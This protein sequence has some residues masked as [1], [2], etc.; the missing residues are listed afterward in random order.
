M[1]GT[2]RYVLALLVT[3]SCWLIHDI[4]RF[5]QRPAMG[6][7]LSSETGWGRYDCVARFHYNS[8]SGA[9]WY[10]FEHESYR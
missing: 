1:L 9:N 2:F 6:Q 4:Q 7:V 10:V 8:Q 3:V 5:A